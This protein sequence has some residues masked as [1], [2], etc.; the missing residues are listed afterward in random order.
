MPWHP[1]ARCA[2]VCQG[3][4]IGN[5]NQGFAEI[6]ALQHLRKDLGRLL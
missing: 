2:L 3:G 6:I 4:I 1:V 5:C